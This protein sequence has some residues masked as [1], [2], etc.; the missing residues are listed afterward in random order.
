MV[1][2]KKMQN[3][4]FLLVMGFSFCTLQACSNDDDDND[5]GGRVSKEELANTEWRV[6][7]EA[8]YYDKEGI[9]APSPG[10]GRDTETWAFYAD[11]TAHIDGGGIGGSSYQVKWKISGSKLILDIFYEGEPDGTETY[12]IV[13]NNK[14][15]T[16]T[17]VL[18]K[19][20]SKKEDYYAPDYRLYTCTYLGEV[21]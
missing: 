19:K 18:K 10:Y 17:I 4:F 12:T 5:G 6:K 8:Y 16:W 3:F 14:E 7:V 2:L 20:A 21:E 11:G 1:K 15:G 13:E 9:P